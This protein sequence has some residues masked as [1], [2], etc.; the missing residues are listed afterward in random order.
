MITFI[1]L[2]VFAIL[3]IGFGMIAWATGKSPRS[4]Q[5][6]VNPQHANHVSIHR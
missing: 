6:G 5:R 4:G 3:G 1:L 2:A